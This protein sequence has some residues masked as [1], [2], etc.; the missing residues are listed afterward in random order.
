M[1]TRKRISMMFRVAATV[2]LFGSVAALA[3][4]MNPGVAPPDSKPYGKTYGEWAAAWGAVD[5]GDPVWG[6]PGQRP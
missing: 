5:R 4:D 6:Q 1:K 2:V 3:Q